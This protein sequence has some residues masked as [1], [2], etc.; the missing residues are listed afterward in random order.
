LADLGI[1]SYQIDNVKRGFTIRDDSALL[2]MRMD[3]TQSL[4]AEY[5]LNNYDETIIYRILK[6]YGELKEAKMIAN[7]ICNYRKTGTIKTVLDI[8]NSMGNFHKVNDAKFLAKIFQALRIEVNNELESLQE[9]L[10]QAKEMLKPSGRL[11]VIS[12]HSLEDRLVKNFMR[13]GA[14]EESTENFS[15]Y[16]NNTSC[17]KAITKKAIQPDDNEIFANNRSRSAK[18]RICEKL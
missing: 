9:F 2:D 17:F 14:F 16:T 7:R 1:S 5:I 8:K 18:L 10:L 4:T 11:V 13:Y 15:L 6:N 12:Y 3:K